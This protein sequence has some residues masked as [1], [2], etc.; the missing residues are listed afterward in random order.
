MEFYHIGADFNVGGCSFNS[1]RDGILPSGIKK[2]KRVQ[3]FVSIPN[4]MEFYKV[5]NVFEVT[6]VEFQFPTGW[7]STKWNTNRRY[8]KFRFQFPTGWNS[9]CGFFRQSLLFDSFNSQRDGIL[10]LFSN[11]FRYIQYS[12]QFPTGWNSTRI[13]PL[14]LAKFESFNSQRDGILHKKRKQRKQKL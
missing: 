9:T 12:F 13:F 11:K 7:N 14:F 5:K 8:K 1:Q 4:G 10:R 2:A 6:N 3:N